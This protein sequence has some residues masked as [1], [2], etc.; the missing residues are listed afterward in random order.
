MARKRNDI[1]STIELVFKIFVYSI[2]IPFW[3]IYMISKM[4]LDIIRYVKYGDAKNA[5]EY[6]LILSCDEQEL[7]D[8]IDNMDGIE[9]EN[10]IAA[11]LKKNGFENIVV[12]KASGDY[13]ADIIGE[14]DNVKYAFQCKRFETK[15]GPKPIGEV[16]RGINY[17]ECDK[18]IVITNNYFSKQAYKEAEVNHV[19]L[20]D[21]EKVLELCRNTFNQLDEDTENGMTTE[22]IHRLTAVIIYLLLSALIIRYDLLF[23]L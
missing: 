16:L 23:W 6:N 22:Q 3:L 7:L 19:E 1:D 21:R 8:E 20:W 13:G 10:F 17:Y 14:Y 9:F 5:D 15:V 2:L 4:I 18:G 11:N 12:T